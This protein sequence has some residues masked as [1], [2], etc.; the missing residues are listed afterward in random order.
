MRWRHNQPTPHASSLPQ[1]VVVHLDPGA[2][3]TNESP[4]HLCDKR[5]SANADGVVADMQLCRRASQEWRCGVC[6]VVLCVPTVEL[7][8]CAALALPSAGV[9]GEAEQPNW[10]DVG[11]GT[12]TS[13]A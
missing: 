13:I 3:E 1:G 12:A 5:A 10:V 2:N 7:C 9:A 6:Y 11:V 8:I 4:R